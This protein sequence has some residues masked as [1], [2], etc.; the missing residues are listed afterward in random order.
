LLVKLGVSSKNA[1]IHGGVDINTKGSDTLTQSGKTVTGS[2]TGDSITGNILT[3]IDGGVPPSIS[4]APSGVAVAVQLPKLGIS[5]G[6][7]SANG[8]AFV[9]VVS[10]IGQTVGGAV[11][12]MLCSSYDVDITINAGLQAQVGLGKFGLCL[13]SPKKLLYEKKGQTHDPGCWQT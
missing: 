13:A 4:L 9:D 12:G 8:I 2:E 6:F 5:L 1:T 3:Q 7:T 11:A 10:A